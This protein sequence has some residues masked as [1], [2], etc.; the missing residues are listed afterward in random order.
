MNKD[1]RTIEFSGQTKI[2]GY[3]HTWT[4]WNDGSN[5]GTQAIIECVE[6]GEV[7]RVDPTLIRFLDGDEE[8]EV[9]S[10]KRNK[11]IEQGAGKL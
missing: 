11:L 1:L 7:F 8:K 2:R 9:R 6:T 3:F 10:F 5:S 4:H